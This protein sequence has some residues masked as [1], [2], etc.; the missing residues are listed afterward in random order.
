M[1]SSF[2]NGTQRS[3]AGAFDR[4]RR[5]KRLFF[6]TFAT[7]FMATA[8][9]VFLLPTKYESKMRLLV[10]SGRQDLVISPNEGRS[11]AAFQDFAE[12]RVNSEIAMMTSRDVLQE[13][14]L[15]SNLQHEPGTV[16]AAGPPSQLYLN[17]AV[18][19]LGRHL[20]I[21]PVKKSDVISVTYKARSPE[22]ATAV[23]KNLADAYLSMHLRAHAKPG[24]FKFFD[25]QADAFAAKLLRSEDQLKHFREEHA[26]TDPEEKT[27]V[28]QKALE[29]EA[30]LDEV[31][32]QAAEY[33]G[34]IQTGLKKLSSL[35]P[36]VVSQV[37][38]SPQTATISQ[39]NTTL[40]E[41][42][43]RRTELLTKFRADDRLVTQLDKEIADTKAE[44]DDLS[45]HQNV[46]TTTDINQVRQETEKDLVAAEIVL[47]GLEDR[48]A[49]LKAILA[50]YK[51]EISDIASASTQSDELSRAV[52]ENEQNYLLYSKQREEAR[53]ADS[54]DRQRIT[55]VSLIEAP[56]YE[57]QPVSPAIPRDLLIGFLMSLM[58]AYAV[59]TAW[60][61]LRP[62][63]EAYGG[64]TVAIPAA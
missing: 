36:R 19:S 7:M 49:K 55:D 11:P 29:A 16:S 62:E 30:A 25:E 45:A 21:E 35:E 46:E 24:S 54:L 42:V 50:G 64:Q 17:T 47:T 34:R 51:G 10:S 40:S 37:H 61:M 14:V 4:I 1:N 13:V 63:H 57:V 56:T 27:P 26:L 8:V 33:T 48:K 43:N 3:E 18:N 28:T 44:L 53:I 39:L 9:V 60:D 5:H 41:L 58:V 38:T 2:V 31:T 32:A 20:T 23:L 12:N 15:R 22:Q 59:V 6:F 52:R